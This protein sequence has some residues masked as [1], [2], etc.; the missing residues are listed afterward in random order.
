MREMS[1]ILRDLGMSDGAVARLR[2]LDRAAAIRELATAA[3]ARGDLRYAHFRHGTR[4][5]RAGE[6]GAA[7]LLGLADPAPAPLPM[8]PPVLHRHRRRRLAPPR[9]S[10]EEVAAALLAAGVTEAEVAAL[11]DEHHC[12]ALSSSLRARGFGAERPLPT[13]QRCAICLEPGVR[14]RDLWFVGV[15]PGGLGASFTM[16]AAAVARGDGGGD[17]GDSGG[18]MASVGGVAGGGPGRVAG[19]GGGGESWKHHECGH[20]F[21]RQCM[22]QSVAV[23]AAEGRR[24]IR[25]PGH[26]EAGSSSSGGGGGGRGGGGGDA[27]GHGRC[28]TNQIFAEHVAALLPAEAFAAWQLKRNEDYRTRLDELLGKRGRDS[29]GGGGGGGGGGSG[30]GGRGGGGGSGGSNDDDEEE[31]LRKFVKAHCKPCPACHVLI[32]RSR[33]CNDMVC[34]CGTRFCFECGDDKTA[35][36]SLPHGD[37]L[38]AC[39]KARRARLR[40]ESAA[41]AATARLAAH[42][43]GAAHREHPRGDHVGDGEWTFVFEGEVPPV[44]VALP[45]PPPPAAPRASQR[46]HLHLRESSWEALDNLFG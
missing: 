5:I 25:C 44:A 34:T 2:R 46:L 8:P 12:R 6:T 18:G 43:R 13:T 3:F 42:N 26:V 32:Y 16:S 35:L 33:G 38:C 22:E 31:G 17:G 11:K 28:C 40:E 41:R 45:P 36:A 20:A 7:T 23:Q 10:A 27:P 9:P 1:D 19:A 24:V 39:G 21:C 15:G 29:G 37:R 30:G 4:S 14:R